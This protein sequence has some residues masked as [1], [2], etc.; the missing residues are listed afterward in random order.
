MLSK[1]QTIKQNKDDTTYMSSEAQADKVSY[2]DPHKEII[3]LC[4]IADE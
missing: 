4:V 1:P 3:Q 2:G